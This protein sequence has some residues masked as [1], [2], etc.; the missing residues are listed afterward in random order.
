MQGKRR[1]LIRWSLGNTVGL[2]CDRPAVLLCPSR[3]PA[4]C[5][6][7]PEGVAR[8]HRKPFVLTAQQYAECWRERIDKEQAALA[9]IVE[10]EKEKKAAADIV[11]A[12]RR[13]AADLAAEKAALAKLPGVERV[14]ALEKQLT[15]ERTKREQLESLLEM[16]K[17]QRGS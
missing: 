8:M 17:S 4:G 1:A 7:R 11:M 10:S 5:A 9:T 16:A 12:E 2:F 15:A 6:R 3:V 13:A 14:Q